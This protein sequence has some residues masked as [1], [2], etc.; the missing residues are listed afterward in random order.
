ML[1]DV[2]QIDSELKEAKRVL[3]DLGRAVTI[4]GSARI[5]E[6]D[7][8][9]VATVNVAKAIAQQGYA[10]ISGGGPGIMAAANQGAVEGGAESVGLN[11]I[12]PREQHPN[13]YQTRSLRFSQFY[14]RK[15]SFFN[16]S[17]AYICMPGGFGTLDE[18]FEVMTLVQTGKLQRSPVILYDSGFWAPVFEW[19]KTTLL[20]KKLISTDTFDWLHMVDSVEAVLAVLDKK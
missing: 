6:D 16:Y 15:M 1:W 4:F 8:Y 18:L 11:I 14:P 5:P 2:H 10:I 19:F 3:N 17:C 7:P 9:Y 20:D 13:P 12:L